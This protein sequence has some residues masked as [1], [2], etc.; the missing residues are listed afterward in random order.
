MN[1]QEVLSDKIAQ[2][3]LKSTELAHLSYTW[4]DGTPRVV[5]ILFHWTGSELV[6]GTPL[7][8]PKMDVLEAGTAVAVS[9]DTAVWPYRA[10]LLRGAATVER[11]ADLPEEY[12]AAC[13]RCAGSDFASVWA[14]QLRTSGLRFARIGLTPTYATIL[15]FETRF[16][17]ATT[18]VFKALLGVS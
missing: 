7:K 18:D 1:V 6:M 13:A 9:I 4:K 11:T 2:D 17:S 8:A 15:D 3:L 14:A 12:V 16:P 5:P 10:L